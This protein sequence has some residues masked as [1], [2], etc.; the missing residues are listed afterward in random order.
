MILEGYHPLSTLDHVVPPHAHPT[1]EAHF[2]V[3]GSGLLEFG[4]RK[5]A[6]GA[7]RRLDLGS[8]DF[9]MVPPAYLHRLVVPPGKRLA[10]VFF[11]CV[12]GPG[13]RAL[14][15]HLE[16]KWGHPKVFSVGAFRTGF[17]ERL[18]Q[19]QASKDPLDREAAGAAFAH[20][21]YELLRRRMGT[22]SNPDRMEI[23]LRRMFERLRGTLDLEEEA[24]VAGV[25]KAFLIRQFRIRWGEPPHRY[26]L[27]MKLDAAGEELCRT[28]FSAASVGEAFGFG[29]PFAFSKMFKKYKGMPPAAWRGARMGGG[30][31]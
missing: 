14:A 18:R 29:D 5:G 15:G 27:R 20:F 23:L 9:F 22:P 26:F 19:D 24:R 30:R 8:G 17:F 31:D 21:L 10:Q 25:S 3:E 4:F 11:Q 7:G 2:V 16:A 6:I 13:D 12:L 1:W 28:G